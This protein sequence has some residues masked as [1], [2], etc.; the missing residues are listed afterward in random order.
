MSELSEPIGN[1][2]ELDEFESFLAK[3]DLEARALVKAVTLEA[4][5]YEVGVSRNRYLGFADSCLRCE[6][7]EAAEAEIKSA[8]ALGLAIAI[9]ESCRRHADTVL[10]LLRK[11]EA[12]RKQAEAEAAAQAE[13]DREN[14]KR[15]AEKRRAQ[16]A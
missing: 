5:I 8:A 12:N 14:R 16:G 11:L 3:V 9:L 15:W 13:R 10:P 6:Q 1:E 4:A 2:E 7:A